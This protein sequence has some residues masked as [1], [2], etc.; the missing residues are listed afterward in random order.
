MV[1]NRYD[2]ARNLDAYESVLRGAP[3]SAAIAPAARVVSMEACP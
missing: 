1:R 2:W 3:P